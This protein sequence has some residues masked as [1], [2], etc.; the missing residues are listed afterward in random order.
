ME[1]GLDELAN[2]EDTMSGRAH[3]IANIAAKTVVSSS[4][5]LSKISPSTIRSLAQSRAAAIATTVT[6][7]GVTATG[8][9][10]NNVKNVRFGRRRSAGITTSPDPTSVPLKPYGQKYQIAREENERR[11][12]LQQQQKKNILVSGKNNLILANGGATSIPYNHPQQS[13]SSSFDGNDNDDDSN[14]G[15]N[16]NGNS[17]GNVRRPV[18]NDQ[19][20]RTADGNTNNNR[21]TDTLSS[22]NNDPSLASLPSGSSNKNPYTGNGSSSN[23]IRDRQAYDPS[24]SQPPM[25]LD[26]HSRS[27][28]I[29]WDTSSTS[30]SV[31]SSKGQRPAMESARSSTMSGYTTMDDSQTPQK[32]H[33]QY[34][35]SAWKRKLRRFKLPL[36]SVPD[37]RKLFRF[38]NR[39]N[40]YH[41]ETLEVWDST[42]K[43]EEKG[44]N[45][46][47]FGFFKRSRSSS[48]MPSS[49]RSHQE[50]NKIEGQQPPL[51]ASM[52]D[53]CQDGKTTSLLRATDVRA[54]IVIGR[55]QAVLDAL[56]IVS[57]IMGFKLMPR[58][59]LP[60]SWD[61]FI[62]VTFPNVG[63]IL[64]ELILG[65]WSLFAFLYAYL[66]KYTRERIFD[67]RIDT[68][69]SYIASSV[70]EESEY[71]QL[72]LRL[73]AAVPMDRSLPNRLASVSKKQVATV[74]SKARLNSYIGIVLASLT[75]MTF[76]A[77]GL[78]L[79]SFSS[80]FTKIILLQEWRQWPV[81]WSSLFSASSSLMQN[82]FQTLEI[83]SNEALWTF[84][85]NPMQYS[86]HISMF[87]S[88]L[89]C[90]LLPGLEERRTV[91]AK[92]S[93]DDLDED[94]ATSNF[95]SAE[96]WSRLGTSSASRL[97]MLSENGSV[98]NALARWQSSRVTSLDKSSL[99]GPV[100]SS[101]LR[102]VAYT[103]VAALVAILPLVVSHLLVGET[104]A[105]S[106]T[107]SILQ[108]DSL[109]DMTFLQFFLFGL[110]YQTL[111]KVMESVE[112]ISFVKSF[113]TD[114][115]NTKKELDDLNKGQAD[116]QVM[117]S[118][119]PSAGIVVR[120][121]WAAHT[122][123]RAWAVRGANLQCK[124][125][126]IL[127]IVGDDGNGK[128][129]LLTTLSEA[130]I[131]PPKRTTTTNKVRG[132]IAICGL[133]SSKWDRKMLK[134][135]LGI[136]LSDVRM[137]ADSASLF[138][139]WTMEEILEPVDGHRPNNNPLQRTLTSA[140][141][142]SMLLSLKITGL[143][144]TL[145][146]RL[147]SKTS[148][149]FTVNEEDL[150][151]T[152]LKP[153]SAVLSPGE[154]SKLILARVLAQTI[155]DNDNVLSS[156]D[157]IENSLIG[158]IL[159]L[160]EPTMMHSEV[161]EGQLLRD[162]RLTGAAT[163]FTTNK[164][165]TGRFAD[166]ICVVKN[167]SIV[168]MGGH[169]DLIARGP[170]QSLYAAKWH[171]MT[172]Q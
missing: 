110:T 105:L 98:E 75:F 52:L 159:L 15:D 86:F 7:P 166:Q 132:F 115:V 138:S 61:D 128:T 37:V 130:L 71:A 25:D 153:R 158:S 113:Q 102:L 88:L 93:V 139:G 142:S 148:T 131:F 160:D 39:N 84:L 21:R 64:N 106:I 168:E 101:L 49:F 109:F 170:Q 165:A 114:L 124:N 95:E 161:E 140:E 32:N 78:V 55:Y 89:I 108:W 8:R 92:N 118:V 53:R 28:R 74:V 111:R 94:V 82:M 57:I 17:G 18:Y 80:T 72:Y 60:Q 116:F 99:N 97:S 26:Q 96:E 42:D 79:V 44:S 40:K 62:S 68:V 121:L 27:S 135:R 125:G 65:S 58:F 100:L 33:N 51:I 36:P 122:T 30:S 164:W 9:N 103:V 6:S 151:P 136:L 24:R 87:A 163:I 50:D 19:Q 127:A 134:R 171:A 4:S 23:N 22:S 20:R 146:A 14:G 16:G 133:E 67:R 2:I 157:K 59:D 5:Q 120:N 172:I 38:R 45:R 10:N 29:P 107:F 91:V 126:E 83:H 41:L 3:K 156:N 147:P 85:N 117:G 137:V 47:I 119:T 129:R 152:S 77:V 54:S 13:Q 90:S 149:I 81:P 48:S 169:N 1:Q 154:W 141:K 63:S 155:F 70:K 167:G 12:Q 11:N 76:S 73:M 162:L 35:M 66:F 104:P 43:D 144:G 150:R 112:H 31:E 69:A 123:K 34:D 143:Y 46:G 56:F 145:L